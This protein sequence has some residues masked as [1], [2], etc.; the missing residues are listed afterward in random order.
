MINNVEKYLNEFYKETKKTSLD[1]M[2]YF[3]NE[4]N[5]FQKDMKNLVIKNK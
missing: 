4:Y 1:A 5:N 3:M 2:K